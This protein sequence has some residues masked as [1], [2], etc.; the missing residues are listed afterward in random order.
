MADMLTQIFEDEGVQEYVN[1]QSQQIEEAATIFHNTPEQIKQHIFENLDAFV[2]PGDL[3]G[4]Y[5]KMTTFTANCVEGLLND[6]T[7]TIVSNTEAE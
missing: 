5:D 7:D 2:V 4:T 3:Q 6:L 1:S